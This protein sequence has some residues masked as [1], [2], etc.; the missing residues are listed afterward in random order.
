MIYSQIPLKCRFIPINTDDEVFRLIFMMNF[1]FYL[2]HAAYEYMK[3]VNQED[4][5]EN[6]NY[7]EGKILFYANWAK[8]LYRVKENMENI[9]NKFC[10]NCFNDKHKKSIIDNID[11]RHIG[12]DFGDLSIINMNR[13]LKLNNVILKNLDL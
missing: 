8:S 9:H 3:I 6:D 5:Y 12:F 4:R 13:A 1:P 7:N 11:S 10:S 2:E